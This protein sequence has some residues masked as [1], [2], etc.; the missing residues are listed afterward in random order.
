MA[1]KVASFADK[2]AKDAKKVIE[3]CP[4]CNAPI[5]IAQLVV[6]KRND[7]TGNW[8]YSKR[9]VKI[10]KCNEKEVYAM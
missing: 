9:S 10:C 1:K 7:E 3:T 2:V 6:S 8:R 4:K 5:Q